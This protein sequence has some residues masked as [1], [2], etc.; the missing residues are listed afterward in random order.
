MTPALLAVLPDTFWLGN[1]DRLPF[2]A[3]IQVGSLVLPPRPARYEGRPVQEP[4]LCVAA[5]PT[6]RPPAPDRKGAIDYMPSLP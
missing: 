2:L 6:A 4:S 5:G 1:R 3:T